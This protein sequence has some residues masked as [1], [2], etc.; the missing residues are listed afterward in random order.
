[1]PSCVAQ[2]SG[3]QTQFFVLVETDSL[4]TELS[5]Q[6]LRVPFLMKILG[7]NSSRQTVPDTGKLEGAGQGNP[8]EK[9]NCSDPGTLSSSSLGNV[10]VSGLDWEP[11]R[12]LLRQ[13]CLS[14]MS[15]LPKPHAAF[16]H[17]L[18]P[19][20]VLSPPPVLQPDPPC[21]PHLRF[22]F[23]GDA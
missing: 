6:P 15:A 13:R 23:S 12:L 9:F 19:H 4:P 16:P 21:H 22:F 7:S 11:W 2:S 5:P 14:E 20:K 8:S 3:D 10:A 17:H 18:H 1:M